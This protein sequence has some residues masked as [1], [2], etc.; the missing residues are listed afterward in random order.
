[1]EQQIRLNGIDINCYQ[2]E[3][4][5]PGGLPLVFLHGITCRWQDFRPLLKELEKDHPVYALDFR[6]HGAS[7][8]TA[9]QYDLP[10][11]AKDTSAFLARLDQPPLIIAHSL[12]GLVASLVLGLGMA[13]AAGMILF[14]PPLFAMEHEISWTRDTFRFWYDTAAAGSG[15]EMIRRIRNKMPGLSENFYRE[16]VEDLQAMDR[17]VLLPVLKLENREY[18]TFPRREILRKIHCPVLIFHGNVQRGAVLSLQEAVYLGE[19]NPRFRFIYLPDAG[20]S[21]HKSR[22]RDLLPEM[23]KF[24]QELDQKSS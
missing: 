20:H 23:R 6:G 3:G 14:D 18:S 4:S 9:D 17:R 8:R 5:R 10:D 2:R 16:R 15:E 11:Y 12:G 13:R 7:G 24:I 19:E 1:M 22:Y 21:F